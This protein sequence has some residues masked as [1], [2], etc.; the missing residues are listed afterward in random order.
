MTKSHGGKGSTPVRKQDTM[1]DIIQTKT[2]PEDPKPARHFQSQ[3][4]NVEALE[5]TKETPGQG[6]FKPNSISEETYD[7]VENSRRQGSKSDFSNSFASDNEENSEETYEDVYKTKGNYS[8]MDLDGKEA[9]KRLQRFFRK[10]KDR[11]KMKKTKSKENISAFSISLPDVEFR[12]QEIIIHDDVNV[13]EKE[14]KDEDKVKARKPKF[15]VPKEK[16]E[17]TAEESESLSPRNFFR[18]KKQNLEKKEWKEKNVLEKDL[19]MTK[20]LLSSTQ[21]WHVP[22]IQ[23]M[24]YLICQ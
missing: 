13:N 16:Q 19:S 7:D 22:I 2:C 11:L 3:C 15:L 17:K 6:A 1:I 9:F 4:G 21:Q 10:E 8:K 5:V 20:R 14:S 24:E 18:T 23:E 12:S